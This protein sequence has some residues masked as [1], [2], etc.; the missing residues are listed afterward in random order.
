MDTKTER[1]STESENNVLKISEKS[2][3]LEENEV[4]NV[5]KNDLDKI[6]LFARNDPEKE[7]W[8]HR[9]NLAAT[10]DIAIEELINKKKTNVE[11]H[12]KFIK[13][14]LA[15]IHN[16]YELSNCPVVTDNQKKKDVS[17][18]YCTNNFK[19]IVLFLINFI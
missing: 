16:V 11:E 2:I 12:N 15:Y 5:W 8:F 4:D 19:I 1:K 13:A 17:Y 3:D 6:Y 9:L 10:F 7:L 18:Q 14:Y